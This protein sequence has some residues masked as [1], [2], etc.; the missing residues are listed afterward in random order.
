MKMFLVKQICLQ[1][2]LD[3]FSKPTISFLEYR[4]LDRGILVQVL[5]EDIDELVDAVIKFSSNDNASG[6]GKCMCI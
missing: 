2:S 3:I 6:A 1:F 5:P 4:M